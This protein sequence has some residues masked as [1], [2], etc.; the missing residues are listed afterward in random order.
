MWKWILICLGVISIANGLYMWFA[1]LAWYEAV[2]GVALMGPFNLHFI[3]DIALVFA[4]SG[5]AMI[6][7]AMRPIPAVAVAGAVWPCMHAIFHVQIWM[8]RGFPFDEVALVNL[9]GIQAP[10]WLALFAAVQLLK[11]GT[12]Q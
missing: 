7:G 11:K 10:S 1:P 12:T 8:A 3:R 4:F 5:G 9:V 2:P 6:F